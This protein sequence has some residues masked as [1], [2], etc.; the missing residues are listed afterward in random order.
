MS[1]QY[2]KIET[3]VHESITVFVDGEM[4]VAIS[5]HPHYEDIV[6]AAKDG[7]PDILDLFDLSRSVDQKFNALSRRVSVSGGNLYFDNEPVHGA[8][9][10][11]VIRFYEEGLD[12]GPLVNFLERLAAN[13]NEHSREQ[14]YNW[15]D[16]RDFTI[17]LSG[18]IVGYKGVAVRD[19]EYLSI[20]SGS[21]IVNGERVKGQIPNSIGSVIE[22]PRSQVA[23]DPRVGCS[24]GLHFGTWEYARGFGRGAV[25][26]VSVDPAD[27][28]SVPTDCDAQ[29]V[30]TCRYTV[31][32]VISQPIASPFDSGGE[33]DDI[34]FGDDD[35][36]EGDLVVLSNGPLYD[37]YVVESV[38]ADGTLTLVDNLGDPVVVSVTEVEL[39]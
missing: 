31:Q 27:I 1:Y 24:T 11:H 5:D 16:G 30:R 8:I 39:L 4:H 28:V 21:A 23:F 33:V 29:K 12:F 7:D 13:P 36:I 18:D 38:N 9:S 35:F 14:L 19:G 2:S 34:G 25:L 20:S 6:Q 37:E 17:N 3:D 26:K 10:E 22:M 32:D 15:L